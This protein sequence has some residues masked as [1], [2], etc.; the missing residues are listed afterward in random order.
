MNQFSL[1]ATVFSTASHSPGEQIRWSVVS[2]LN[3]PTVKKWRERN[4]ANHP[5]TEDAGCFYR[6]IHFISLRSH[7]G[8][9]THPVLVAIVYINY[10][11]QRDVFSVQCGINLV[12][13]KVL[14]SQRFPK[15]LDWTGSTAEQKRFRFV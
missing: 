3:S 12:E 2:Q 8:T 5:S 14:F 9:R 13:R 15:S 6:T 11:E 7:R 1:G 10:T 4:R